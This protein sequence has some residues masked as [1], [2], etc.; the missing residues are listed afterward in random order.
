M[1]ININP[2]DEFTTVITIPTD[3]D[4]A[5]GTEVALTTQALANREENNNSRLNT[6][7]QLVTTTNFLIDQMAGQ[8]TMLG[9]FQ[10]PSFLTGP[11]APGGWLQ[12]TDNVSHVVFEIQ[13]SLPRAGAT[14]DTV[15]A[16]VVSDGGSHPGEPVQLPELSLYRFTKESG[17][18][19]TIDTQ[20]D[21]FV[22]VAVY[23]L[24]HTISLT[25]IGHTILADTRYGISVRGESGTN[26][27]ALSFNLISLELGWTVP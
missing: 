13:N 19:T 16:Y 21:P 8:P 24:P 6:V 7:P 3:G 2:V 27:L 10:D 23:E 5:T 15:T 1:S 14:L 20:L 17:A 12:V 22:S 4:L 9:G 26:A 18:K 25:S 11:S